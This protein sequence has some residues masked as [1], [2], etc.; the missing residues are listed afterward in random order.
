MRRTQNAEPAVPVADVCLLLEGT[1]PYVRGGVSSWINQMILG[2]P[3]VTFSVLF[4]GGQRDAYPRRNYEIPPNVVHIEEVY[5]AD[6]WHTGITAKGTVRQGPQA[7]LEDLY[8]YFHHPDEPDVAVGEQLLD[9]LAQG[10]LELADVLHSRASWSVVSQGYLSHC[11]DPSFINYFWTLRTMQSPLLMLA[12]VA[13]RMP[14]ARALHAISTG[15]AGL[16]GCILK[17][18]WQCDF[19]LSEHGI[20]TK[21]RKIDLAQADW[22]AE[23]PDEALSGSLDTGTGY[24]RSLWIRFFERIGLLVYRSAD[25]IIALYDGNRKRQIKD[26][27]DPARTRVIPNGIDLE[28]WSQVLA[29]R[30]PGIAPVV[31]L[32]G[33]VVPIKDVKTFIRAIRGVVSAMPEAEAWIVGPEDEDAA[34]AAECHSLVSSL[35]LTDKVRFLGFQRIQEILPKLGLMVLTSIS[36]A[37]PLVILEAWCAGTPVVSSDV[38]SCRE[39]IEGGEPE[40]RALGLAGEVVAI[41]DP[42]ATARAILELLRDPQRWASA[43]AAGLARVNRYYGEALMLQRYRDLYRAATE[44]H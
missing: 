24:I 43:Q 33:R 2:L 35:G 12:E 9:A 44:K 30:P 4:I 7:V 40:D 39:L 21:E 28:R 18:L 17:R 36:E 3:D 20:Y 11:S 15:Y 38:G 29:E 25:P 41:A 32:I 6:S 16:A 34:Y 23:N 37:Q 10:R 13:Q 8:R 27:A 26:G 31:G 22:I 5:L 1:W 19:L 42:Q 14:R